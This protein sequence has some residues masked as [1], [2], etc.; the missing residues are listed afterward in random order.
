M[1][2]GS[3]ELP[4]QG[5]F[6]PL[7]DSIGWIVHLNGYRINYYRLILNMDLHKNQYI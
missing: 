6:N 5:F 7:L 3:K 2:R 1:T 4:T